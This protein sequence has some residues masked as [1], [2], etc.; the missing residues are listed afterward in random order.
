MITVLDDNC[1]TY[2]ED[3]AGD[4]IFADC[5]KTSLWYYLK[6]KINC[7]IAVMRDLIGNVINIENN[8]NNNNNIDNTNNNNNLAHLDECK[9]AS[10]AKF[11]K[12]EYESVLEYVSQQPGNFSMLKTM[13]S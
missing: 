4:I 6:P 5:C 2:P 8:N 9:T 11:A 1:K 12:R 7:T 13:P 10:D 3:N